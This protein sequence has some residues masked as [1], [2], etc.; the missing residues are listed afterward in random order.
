MSLHISS[1][2]EAVEVEPGRTRRIIHTDNLMLVAWD[3][4]GGPWDK[5]DAPH[6]HPHEQVAYIVEG[7][8]LF[9][10]GDET[11]RLKTGDMVAVPSEIP[12]CI[13]LIS[14]IVRLIDAFTPIRHE[15]L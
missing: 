9:F 2:T 14:P 5:P 6:T 3:F 12:H 8:L 13:Q 15:F 10:L 7:E 4:Y 11:Q 1:D